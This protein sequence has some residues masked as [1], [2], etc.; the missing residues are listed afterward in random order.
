MGEISQE[1]ADKLPSAIA[2]DRDVG[3]V[4]HLK[5]LTAQSGVG[6]EEKANNFKAA[7]QQAWEPVGQLLARLGAHGVEATWFGCVG[8]A[9]VP[10]K[11]VEDIAAHPNVL[12]MDSAVPSRPMTAV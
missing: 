4:I 9:W 10:A 11:V 5:P 3:V 1:L 6:R 12:R 7:F 2:E 8:V